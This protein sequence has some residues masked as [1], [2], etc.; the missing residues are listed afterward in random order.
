MVST[1][2]DELYKGTFNTIAIAVAI[3]TALSV[4]NAVELLLRILFQFK[5]WQGKYFWSLVVGGLSVVLYSLGYM[6][7]FFRIGPLLVGVVVNNIGWIAMVCSQSIVL[8]SRLH[9]VL[10]NRMILN[11]ILG[12]II[13]NGIVWY[14]LATTMEFGSILTDRHSYISGSHVVEKLQMTFFTTQELLISGVY[15]GQIFQIFKVTANYNRRRA[16]W[17]LFTVQAIIIAMDIV[18]LTLEYLD[19]IVYQSAFKSVCYSIKLGLEFAVLG[20]LIESVGRGRAFDFSRDGRGVLATA[21]ASGKRQ[22]TIQ[23][24]RCDSGSAIMTVS[25]E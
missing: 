8:H 25:N 23:L 3:F 17:H 21:N 12:M 18:L 13:A 2:N 6:L 15:I 11:G 14:T 10:D 22:T 5:R 7:Y 9:L 16:I 20:E 1:P 19:K 4:C 24:E